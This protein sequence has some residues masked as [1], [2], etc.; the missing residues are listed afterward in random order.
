MAAIKAVREHPGLPL[1]ILTIFLSLQVSTLKD[2]I[3][4]PLS[5]QGH[6]QNH[7]LGIFVS[8][9]SKTHA[10]MNWS[11]QYSSPTLSSEI[12]G[13]PIIVLNTVKAAIDLLDKKGAIYCDRPRFV[14]FEVMGWRKTLT[15]LRSGPEF[16]IHRR[17]LQKA[18]TQGNIKQ[19]RLLQETEV[20]VMLK[21]IFQNVER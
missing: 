14:L 9:R 5:H 19:Y 1:I 2:E 8:S 6:Q 13:Q 21:I 15:F 7:F 11:K 3:I 20:S 16:R 4:R 12:F 18:L 10:Y 17:L